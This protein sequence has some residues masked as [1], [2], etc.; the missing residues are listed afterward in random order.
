MFFAAK[1]KRDKSN[2]PVLVASFASS[3]E[4]EQNVGFGF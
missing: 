4:L 1:K 3:S 2:W